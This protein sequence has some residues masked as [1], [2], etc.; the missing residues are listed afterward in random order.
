[1]KLFSGTGVAVVTP[2]REDL[3]PDFPSLRRI[4]NHLIDG[5]VEY[6]VVMGTTG[7]SVTLNQSE[8]NQVLETFLETSDKRVP[9]VMGVGGNNTQS[10]CKKAEELSS[11]YPLDGILSVSPY[12]N[13]PTQAGIYQHYKALSESTDL[14]II[15]YNVPGR[16]A[17]NVSPETTLA[18]AHDCDN[19][20]ATKEASGNLPQ[21][22]EIIQDKPE[23][24]LVLSG[25]D[26]LALPFIGIGADGVIS[27]IGNAL[28]LPFSNMVRAALEGDFKLA[29]Q[30]HYDLL[31]LMN[32]NFVEGNPAGVKMLM[33]L[34][35]LCEPY[36]RLP[37]IA[38]SES[39]RN[40]L[41]QALQLS[42]HP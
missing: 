23:G 20:V 6:L 42:V 15:L 25:D 13:K 31:D 19:I 21:V 8:Q 1:M 36:V 37:L 41:Q 5:K 14:P 38:A 10:I 11:K 34:M 18:L 7:E 17:S 32:L 39:L 9:I 16:T 28:P 29:Q 12:Y 22:M 40:K 24:F 26:S 3:T 35:G 30:I 27:V 2:F 33:N 4:I